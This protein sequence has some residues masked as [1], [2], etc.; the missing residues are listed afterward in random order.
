MANTKTPNDALRIV[1]KLPPFRS[2]Q[3]NTSAFQ[4]E[5]VNEAAR[6]MWN[7]HEWRVSLAELPPF[8]L[9]P[10]EPDVS[11]LA[12]P[13]PLD[14][15]YLEDAWLAFSSGGE[16]IGLQTS[17]NLQRTRIESRPERLAYNPELD[18]WRVWP[19]PS[20]A[21]TSP[22][23]HVEGRYKKNPPVW[24]NGDWAT[25]VLPWDDRF[26]RVYRKCLEYTILDFLGNPAAG[27]VQF[28]NG[29][30]SYS[31][32]LAEYH[33]A[34]AEALDFENQHGGEVQVSPEGGS[35]GSG[36]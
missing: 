19:S 30:Q 1:E 3:M 35:I 4:I 23:C 36:F 16:T 8:Y 20:S 27:Q 10:G 24:D 15:N 11:P 25:K 9:T 28:V 22:E 29:R 31:G 18:R 32:K 26:F 14:F 6:R 33:D 2:Q 12:A 13:I 34:L 17:Q 7:D 5:A 21:Y